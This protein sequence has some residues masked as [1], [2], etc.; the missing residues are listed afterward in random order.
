[1]AEPDPRYVSITP[2]LKELANPSEW[3]DPVQASK[4]AGALSLLLDDKLNETQ[5]AALLSLLHYKKKDQD[6]AVINECVRTI[7]QAQPAVE[8]A[9][10]RKIV[11]DRGLARGRYSGGLCEIAG[12]AGNATPTISVTTAASIIASPLLMIAQHGYTSATAPIPRVE[13]D[14]ILPSIRPAPPALDSITPETVTE[15]YK[16]SSYALLPE[17]SFYPGMKHANPIRRG[18]DIRTIFDLIGTLLHPIAE[19]EGMEARVVGVSNPDLGPALIQALK[20]LGVGKALVVSGHGA[21]DQISPEGPTSCW[22]LSKPVD[23]TS[24]VQ[25][26]QF[27]LHPSDFGLP[28]IP[29]NAV[30][31][32]SCAPEE[33]KTLLDMLEGKLPENNPIVQFVLMHAAVLFVTSGICEAEQT[34]SFSGDREVITERGPGNGRWKEGLRLARQC[35]QSGQ[36][37]RSLETY[38]RVSNSI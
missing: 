12:T 15:V 14:D 22:M 7:S 4:I 34:G 32:E 29:L 10:V 8:H 1:M 20:D 5:A 21:L 19:N 13:P 35:L 6:V 38:I 2:L 16:S 3:T 30:K 24:P 36:A 17:S 33:A 18:L 26:E 11:S 31:A 27:Q 9:A 28:I 23:G 25:I 37:L